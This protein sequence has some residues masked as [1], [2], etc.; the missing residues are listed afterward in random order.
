MSIVITQ[1]LVASASGDTSLKLARIGYENLVRGNTPSVS[2]TATGFFA[3]ALRNSLTHEFWKPTASPATIEWTGLSATV[4]YIGI[5]AHTLGS[6][7]VTVKLEYSTDNGS[8]Y[9]E[10]KE[11]IHGTDND[12]MVLFDEVTNVTNVK[13]TLTYTGD[14]PVIG[15]IYVG[16][17][18]VMQQKLYGGHSPITLSRRTS[19]RPQASNSG[20]WIGRSI[21]R[22]AFQSSAA[23]THLT[24]EWY[25]NNF[26]PFV[27]EAL[28]YPFFFAWNPS[29]WENE[30]ALCWTNDDI[31]PSNM[32]MRDRMEVSM[33]LQGYGVDA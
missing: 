25:R 10:I 26:D 15:V 12:I 33:N 30:V 7:S 3:G 8:S 13:I 11:F 9:T 22:R 5:A 31:Q 18:L 16:K 2:T 4:D 23:W 24:A 21:I 20:Q 19:K 14:A 6:E 1:N 32:G 27:K 28:K 17:S 29:E